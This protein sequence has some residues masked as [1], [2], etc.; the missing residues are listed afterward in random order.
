MHALQK[1]LVYLPAVV[2]ACLGLSFQQHFGVFVG[3]RVSLSVLR[4]VDLVTM[5][6]CPLFLSNGL[7]TR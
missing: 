7:A 6:A 3:V 1:L 2:D 4:F 5:H